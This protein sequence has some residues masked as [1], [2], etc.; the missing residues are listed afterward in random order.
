MPHVNVLQSKILN[1]VYFLTRR[2]SSSFRQRNERVQFYCYMLYGFGLPCLFTFIVYGLDRIDSIP[3]HYRPG[4][5]HGTCFIQREN[6]NIFN[7]VYPINGLIDFF[8]ICYLLSNWIIKLK[9]RCT[10]NYRWLDCT[11]SVPQLAA[12]NHFHLEHC[13]LFTNC[14]YIPS[15]LSGNSSNVVTREFIASK[16]LAKKTRHV[17]GAWNYFKICKSME[18]FYCRFIL[19]LRLSVVMGISWILEVIS[20]LVAADSLIFMAGD[21]WNTLQGVFIFILFIMRRRVLRLIKERFVFFTLPNML[22]RWFN[23]IINDFIF[24]LI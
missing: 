17:S 2:S 14:N 7:F 5:G 16:N 15:S 10:I 19:Y 6:W 22:K 9:L 1:W 8:L 3:Q 4:I 24:F 11:V 18:T 23:K 20:F 21:M 12:W 13:A